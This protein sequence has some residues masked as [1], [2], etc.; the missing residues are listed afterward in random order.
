[1]CAPFIKVASMDLNNYPFLDYIARKK[2]PVII[3]TG[4]SELS[5]IDKAVK[6]I[7]SA[8]NNNIVI[9]HCVATY[10]PADTDVNLN[11]IKTM[12]AAFPDY[13]IGFSDHTIGSVVPLSAVTLGACVL[14]KHFTLDKEMEGWDH[15]VSATKDEL[16]DIIYGSKRIVD[17]LGSYRI[18]AT[19]SEVQR[20]EFRRSIVVTRDMK[21][22]DIIATSDLDYKRPAG[23][24]DPEMTEYLVGRTMRRDLG[25]DPC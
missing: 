16:T 17:A 9:L 20:R 23:G 12:M 15:K 8:G 19:E 13:P 24:F 11:N 18:S 4:L 6:T 2:I 1:M 21:A 22:G 14:E 7:E 5:E 25:A 3:S 10:P